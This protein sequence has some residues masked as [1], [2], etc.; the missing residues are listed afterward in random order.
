MIDMDKEYQIGDG[1]G[2]RIICVDGP[3]KR[4]ISGFI[5]HDDCSWRWTAEGQHRTEFSS[6]L[7]DL[8][9][10]L[11]GVPWTDLRPGDYF[12]FI[13]TSAQSSSGMRGALN[14]MFALPYSEPTASMS[15]EK[16]RHNFRWMW[17]YSGTGRMYTFKPED[18]VALDRKSF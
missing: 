11:P 6:P 15:K 14:R 9:E 4:P 7:Y 2:V 8:V 16:I 18:R 17:E 5:E 13:G 3:G 12:H 10:V 1:R